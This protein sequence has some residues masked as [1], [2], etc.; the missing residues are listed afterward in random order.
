MSLL[1]EHSTLKERERE[2]EKS[3]NFY[4]RSV[5]S[6]KIDP[7]GARGPIELE[8]ISFFQLSPW[9]HSGAKKIVK[10]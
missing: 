7:E 5:K 6:C 4:L 3:T 1:G 10:M 8:S 2:N 9:L